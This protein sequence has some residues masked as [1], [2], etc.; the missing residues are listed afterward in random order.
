MRKSLFAVASLLALAS[1]PTE[2]QTSST[3]GWMLNA[4]LAGAAIG[5]AVEDADMWRGPGLGAAVGY[6][7]TERLGL[8]LNVDATR[9]DYPGPDMADGPGGTY[10]L[11]TVDIALRASFR[12]EFSSLRPYLTSGITGVVR[13]PR[14]NDVE[15]AYSG[16]GITLG[17]GLQY[18]TSRTLAVDLGVDFTSGSFIEVEVDGDVTEFDEAEGFSHSRVRVGVTWHPRPGI[19][20]RTRAGELRFQPPGGRQGLRRRAEASAF[21]TAAAPRHRGIR[22]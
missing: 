3:R 10:D 2:A 9:A 4:H 7:F 21:V 16:G 18:F 8:L 17:G 20:Y 6:G 12:D 1:G 22:S 13:S 14:L 5:S 11:V 15:I 19:S